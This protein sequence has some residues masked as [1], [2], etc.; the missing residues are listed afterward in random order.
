MLYDKYCCNSIKSSYYF[1]RSLAKNAS[2]AAKADLAV[3][4]AKL[5]QLEEDMCGKA[6]GGR[7]GVVAA[8]ARSVTGAQA[9]PELLQVRAA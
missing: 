5:A 3:A 6:M 8:L 7:A 1:F 9:L 2:A 4:N